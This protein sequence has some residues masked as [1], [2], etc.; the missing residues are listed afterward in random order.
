MQQSRFTKNI[1]YIA[2]FTTVVVITWVAS[3][4]WYAL[5]NP[6][7][8]AD[9]SKYTT[10]IEANFDMETLQQLEGRIS[11]PV[12]LSQQGNYITDPNETRSSSPSA[13]FLID[14]PTPSQDQPVLGEEAPLPPDNTQTVSPQNNAL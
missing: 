1:L 5:T 10:P 9:T 2:I 14:Q 3:T 11:L 4:V 7:V 8:P 12:D 6:T 13:D